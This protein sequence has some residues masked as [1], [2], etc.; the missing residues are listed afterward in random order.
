MGIMMFVAVAIAERLLM[1]WYHTEKKR[2]A[3]SR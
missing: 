1:P 2:N 3:L